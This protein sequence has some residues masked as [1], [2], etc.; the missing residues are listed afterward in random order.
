MITGQRRRY[1]DGNY[2]LD[3]PK[4]DGSF[5]PAKGNWGAWELA[6]R[7]SDIDRLSPS[8]TS[9]QTPVGAEIGQAY[10]TATALFQ[11]AL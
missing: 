7:Y 4:V 3:G 2:A 1:N 6:L 10:D 5:N 8:A 9:Y 11:L